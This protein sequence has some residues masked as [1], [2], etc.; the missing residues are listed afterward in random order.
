VLRATFAG[1]VLLAS[2]SAWAVEEE[3]CAKV[4][5]VPKDG[6]VYL[7]RGPGAEFPI[8]APLVL[9]DFPIC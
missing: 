2:S 8:G 6:L 1:M 7:R 4:T 9:N 3:F 5:S